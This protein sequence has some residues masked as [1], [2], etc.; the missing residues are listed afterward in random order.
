MRVMM[1]LKSDA[2]AESGAPPDQKLLTDMGNYNA[3]MLE[4][5]VL[6][7]AEGLRPTSEGAKVRISKGKTV[8]IDGPFA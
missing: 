4:A 3:A 8:V 7:G 1:L 6:V 2:T 5:G